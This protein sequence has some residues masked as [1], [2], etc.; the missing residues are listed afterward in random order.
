MKGLIQAALLEDAAHQDITT[1][2][3]ISRA[4]KVTARIFARE[5]G[6][7]CGL[8]L[9]R[10]VFRMFDRTLAVRLLKNDGA[11]VRAKETL[12]TVKGRARSVLSCERLALNFLGYLSGIATQTSQA[13]RVVRRRGIRI[14]DTRKTTPL[15]RA[16]EKYAV[17][18]GGGKNHRFN[19][20]DQ[21]LVKDNHILILR[22]T[23]GFEALFHRRKKIPF[24]I[25]VE[26]LKDME[27][28]L[29]Y[30]PDIV[31]LD[32]FSPRDVRRAILLLKRLFSDKKRRPLIELSGGITP[33]NI[34]SYAIK[35]VDFISLGALTHSARSLDVSLE[36]LEV[37]V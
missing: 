29:V 26:N 37:H 11:A 24:E 6:V 19:L 18:A 35:G 15:L 21:Y 25:E 28:A 30:G 34:A 8:D 5:N 9:A 3:F 13:S 2:D 12:L 10:E 7:V 32:N 27:R 17:A 14:L 4:A 23:K 20:A 31:M 36:I 1:L 33:Q 22:E 16:L